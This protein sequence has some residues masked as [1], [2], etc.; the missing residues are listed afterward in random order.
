LADTDIRRL[1][2]EIALRISLAMLT[3]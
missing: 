1:R 2:D 3:Q